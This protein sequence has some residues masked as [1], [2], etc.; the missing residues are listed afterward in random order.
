MGNCRGSARVV[1]V[2]GVP[3]SADSRI[4]KEGMT[5]LDYFEKAVVPGNLSLFEALNSAFRCWMLRFR[6]SFAAFDPLC[7]P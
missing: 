5:P 7:H 2:Y 6:N 3:T 4:Y 1:S